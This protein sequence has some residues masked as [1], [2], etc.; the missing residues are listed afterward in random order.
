M[1]FTLQQAIQ[2]S[3]LPLVCITALVAYRLFLTRK[4]RAYKVVVVG[5]VSLFLS[6]LLQLSVGLDWF[7]TMQ[8]VFNRGA[9]GLF[10]VGCYLSIFGVS[11]LFRVVNRKLRLLIYAGSIVIFLG[12]VL[13]PLISSI[14]FIISGA[15]VIFYI[16]KWVMHSHKVIPALIGCYMVAEAGRT[17]D[18]LLTSEIGLWIHL[19]GYM[20]FIILL[21]FLLIERVADR[22]GKFERD[23][24]V[25]L[26][27]GLFNR[28]YF[29]VLLK[30]YI[31]RKRPVHL[32]FIDLDNFKNLNDTMG[33]D[34]GDEAL[35]TVSQILM[36]E[37]EN[38]G[39]AGRYGGEE[40]V[41]L[42][43]KQ[44]KIDDFAEKIRYRIESESSPRVTASIGFSSWSEG[45]SLDDLIQRAD[46]AM[47]HSKTTGKNKVTAF[48]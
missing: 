6:L 29:T 39:F 16:N 40:L 26:L 25:D 31:D 41:M 12:V 8:A 9:I 20:L 42:V 36:E 38:S 23:S 10:E 4:K 35:R 11:H 37:V 47:Y 17:V 33:H 13:F 5:N 3:I 34:K 45:M 15:I 28:R 22:L 1:T 46:K 7:P 44:V 24:A 21:V 48:V 27:T 19:I 43:T 2:F 30:R 18:L 14:V 32:V